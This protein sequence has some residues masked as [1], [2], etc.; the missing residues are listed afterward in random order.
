MIFRKL[1]A[2]AKEPE[3]ATAHSAGLDI[4]SLEEVTIMP[5][6]TAKIRTGIC[7]ENESNDLSAS[8]YI[9]LRVRSSIAAKGL[10][11]ANGAGVIDA[12]YEGREIIVLIHNVTKDV[13]IIGK[14]EKIAQM[15]I[16]SHLSNT[17]NGV[18]FKYDKRVGGMG[19]TSL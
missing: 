3:R 15:I 14:G 7:F 10:I 8:W 17:A 5:G 12:D 1:S 4:F 6:E 9:D 13:N 18:T 19:S 11:L 2:E 16:Q